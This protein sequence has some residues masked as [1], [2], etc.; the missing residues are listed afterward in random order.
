MPRQATVG[1]LQEFA[2]HDPGLSP[3]ID[4]DGEYRALEL[5][6]GAALGEIQDR[7]RL[8]HAAFDPD[9]LPGTL[10]VPAAERAMQIILAADRLSRYWRSHGAPPPSGLAPCEPAR[11][12]DAGP[13]PAAPEAPAAARPATR[14]H[15]VAQAVQ[16]QVRSTT[17]QRTGAEP[18]AAPHAATAS[19]SARKRSRG[20]PEELQTRRKLAIAGSLLVKLALAGLVVAAV[21]RVQQYRAD[22][23][24]LSAYSDPNTAIVTGMPVEPPVRWA[25]LPVRG[26]QVI[27]AAAPAI[28]GR[29]RQE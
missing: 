2:E 22:H 5:P 20:Q 11:R 25:G 14:L 24:S 12:S 4:Y 27:G 13:L 9:D 10:W 16:P 26:P 19:R 18:S 28:G 1:A 23:P 7:A 3:P 17:P 8:L 29:Q 6:P 15:I 21:A